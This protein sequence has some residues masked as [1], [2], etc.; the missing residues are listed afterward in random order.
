METVFSY[1]ILFLQEWKPSLKFV[2]IERNSA[3]SGI[4]FLLFRAFF[5]QVEAL[6]ETN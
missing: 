5:L 1:L 6:T 2:P 4:F 3:P